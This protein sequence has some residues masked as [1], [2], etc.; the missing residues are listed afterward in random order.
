MS[1]GK[2]LLRDRSFWFSYL[3]LFAT[4][5]ISVATYLRRFNWGHLGPLLVTHWLGW[6]ATIFIVAYTPLYFWLKRRY[7]RHVKTLVDIHVF[8]NLAS[9]MGISHHFATQFSRPEFFRPE[10]G[11]GFITYISI[12][13]LVSTGFLYRYRILGVF[14]RRMK[15]V[16]VPHYNRALHITI[17][18]TFY[19][20]VVFHVFQAIAP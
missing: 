20:I 10:Y 2:S 3:L 4:V 11:L 7:I 12:V 13:I 15:Q 1:G 8:G 19:F 16:R 17:T 18:L 14:D 5:N 6:G 9:F